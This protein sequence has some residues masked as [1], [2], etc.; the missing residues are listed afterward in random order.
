MEKYPKEEISIG[1][2]NICAA[3]VTDKISLIYFHLTKESQ[4]LKTGLIN[5]I[6]KTAKNESCNPKSYF[7][8]KGLKNNITPKAITSVQRLKAFL[9]N[10]SAKNIRLIIIPERT[11][12][13]GIPVKKI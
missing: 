8:S 12:E 11:P 4:L 7:K 13:A 2:V 1:K 3:K 5:I 10:I 9:S 6:P